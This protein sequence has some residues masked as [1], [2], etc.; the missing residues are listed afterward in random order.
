MQL[1]TISLF[2][3]VIILESIMSDNNNDQIKTP[4]R[5]PQPLKEFNLIALIPQV[6]KNWYWFMVTIPI[7][8]LCARF[9]ISHT[10]PI[11]RSYATVLIDETDDRP[12]VDNSELLVGLGLPGGMKNIENQIAILKSRSLTKSTLEELPF[13]IEYFF[14]TFRNK[15]PVYPSN[16]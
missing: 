14:R 1:T 12:L 9:Y 10:L 11:Y 16:Q 8:L 2:L 4:D 3:L 13:E 15:L 7:A 6:L 5:S